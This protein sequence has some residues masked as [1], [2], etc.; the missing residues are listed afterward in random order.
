MGKKREREKKKKKKKVAD[1]PYCCVLPAKMCCVS[2]C[3]LWRI[4]RKDRQQVV[5]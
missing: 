1:I 3:V 5:T 4:L 2:Q